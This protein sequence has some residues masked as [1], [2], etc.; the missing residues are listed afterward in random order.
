MISHVHINNNIDDTKP[1]KIEIIIATSVIIL[2][3]ARIVSGVVFPHLQFEHAE[4]NEAILMD[5]QAVVETPEDTVVSETVAETIVE[6]VEKVAQEKALDKEADLAMY[7]QM[8]QENPDMYGW[9]SI[10]GTPISYPV[11]YSPDDPEKYLK[12]QFYGEYSESGLP[13]IDSRCSIDP[14]SD[15]LIIYAHNKKDGSMFASLLNYQSE[16]YF[17]EHP[18]I[19]FNTPTEIREYKI[20]AAFFDRVYYED[21]DTY[22]FYNFIDAEYESDYVYNICRLKGKSIYDTGVMPEY[23]DDIVMLVTCAYHVDNGRFVVVACR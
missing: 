16:D 14:L 4:E 5:N 6:P 20:I 18:T 15:N 10:D 1:S 17:K 9:I 11:M 8:Q 7:Q 13:F 23:G 2:G 12:T 21:E 3:I 22:K 19:Y